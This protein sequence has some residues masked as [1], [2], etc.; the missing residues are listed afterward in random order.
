MGTRNIMNLRK[1][2]DIGLQWLPQLAVLLPTAWARLLARPR[3]TTGQSTFTP[4][5]LTETETPSYARLT[6]V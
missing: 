6:N 2:P 5:C 1:C 3:R 4:E